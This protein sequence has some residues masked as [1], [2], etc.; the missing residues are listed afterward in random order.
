M[1]R[2]EQSL[3]DEAQLLP[4]QP[5]EQH[6]AEGVKVRQVLEHQGILQRLIRR[7]PKANLVHLIRREEDAIGFTHLRQARRISR[8]PAKDH[9]K[10]KR[11]REDSLKAI[12][13]C[14][15]CK[16]CKSRIACQMLQNRAQR[17]LPDAV[18]HVM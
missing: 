1:T 13:C 11:S 16:S 4:H 17:R 6:D 12:K 7:C 5:K 14:K 9:P 18:K 10:D 2:S 3:R 8:K 15:S